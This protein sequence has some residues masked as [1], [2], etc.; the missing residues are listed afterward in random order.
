MGNHPSAPIPIQWFAA[1]LHII[2]EPSKLPYYEAVIRKIFDRAETFPQLRL[3]FINCPVKSTVN[4]AGEAFLFYGLE[5]DLYNA[6]FRPME[7]PNQGMDEKERLAFREMI[8]N[9]GK[10]NG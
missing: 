9:G 1:P 3:D 8:L 2:N 6:G 5:D 7:I 10:L 4:L